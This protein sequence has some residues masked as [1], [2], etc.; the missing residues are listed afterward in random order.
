[1]DL[2][3]TQIKV[4]SA[5][6][7]SGLASLWGYEDYHAI[8][9]GVVTP[10]DSNKIILFVT[11]EKQHHL[12]QYHDNLANGVLEWDGPEDHWA[13][14]R[15]TASPRSVDEIHL[16]YRLKH[17]EP[18][19]YI[20]Q[21]LLES[22]KKYIDRPSRFVFSTVD[23]I[24]KTK[25]GL[26]WTAE[27]IDSI[28]EDYFALRSKFLHKEKYVKADYYRTSEE[29]TGRTR[30]S[31]E[32]KYRNISAT[33]ERLSLPW[34]QGCSP[35][36]NFQ[37]EL[38]RSV[39]K[40]VCSEW[41]KDITE[42]PVIPG[43]TELEHPFVHAPPDLSDPIKSTNQE[44]ERLARK[45]DA[46]W[47]DDRNRR[48][49]D[50]GEKLVVEHEVSRLKS[51]GRP[52]LAKKVKWVSKEE[53]DGAGYDIRSYTPN[54]AERLLEVKTTIGH[55]RTPF[56]LTRNE[57]EVANEKPEKFRIFRLHDW[58][59]QLGAFIIKPPLESSLIL[60]PTIYMAS[61]G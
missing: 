31:V 55:E 45:F 52:D 4:G 22:F 34:I 48:L 42:V 32:Y 54:G 28:V 35:L 46:A 29:K 18:F 17:H 47:R 7:R 27:E 20:G 39:E 33:L 36:H 57:R 14:E 53:G 26:E 24:T 3:F 30:K 1:M 16:F 38:L 12:V 50:A 51:F 8:A 44:L 60:E 40:R 43:F 23:D 25:Y 19:I 15:M 5:Y 61:F 11:Q 2:P 56:Y 9:R 6:T 37:S 59:T 10:R 49:G 58:G 41:V 21:L 13:E